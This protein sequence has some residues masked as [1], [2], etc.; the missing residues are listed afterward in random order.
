MGLFSKKKEEFVSPMQGKLL[1]LTDVPDEVFS[2]KMMGDGFAVSLTSGTITAPVSG[3]ITVA[4]PTK[5]AIGLKTKDG[6]ELLLH[7]GM[8]TV[9][10]NGEGFTS[11]ITAGKKV[12]QGDV[13]LE[14]DLVKVQAAGKSIVSPVIFTSGEQIQLRKETDV[15]NGDTGFLSIS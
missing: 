1:P 13:L 6:L 15:K 7:I 5:H 4:F 10:L 8:D 2:Q 3:E 14:V 12:K 11:Y 9:E